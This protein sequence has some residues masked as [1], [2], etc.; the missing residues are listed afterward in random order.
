[1]QSPCGGISLLGSNQGAHQEL[2]PL[3]CRIHAKKNSVVDLTSHST[4]SF[5]WVSPCQPKHVPGFISCEKLITNHNRQVVISY[6][7]YTSFYCFKRIWLPR[8]YKLMDLSRNPNYKGRIYPGLSLR[9]YQTRFPAHSR[10][11]SSECNLQ[12]NHHWS[13]QGGMS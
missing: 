5:I 11:L 6:G 3:Q 8:F 1:V 10:Y 9:V 13:L 12:S 7:D 2:H 4:V